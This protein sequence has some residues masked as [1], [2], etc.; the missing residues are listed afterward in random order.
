MA[1]ADDTTPGFPPRTEVTST[2]PDSALENSNIPISATVYLANVRSLAMQR[3]E[4]AGPQTA[5]RGK[6]DGISG[7]SADVT[8]SMVIKSARAPHTSATNEKDELKFRVELAEVPMALPH[9]S[10]AP[11][12]AKVEH[13]NDS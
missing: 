10:S 11:S 13:H 3:S 9:L 5:N 7:A 2:L 6:D 12:I 8:R 4:P 1:Q